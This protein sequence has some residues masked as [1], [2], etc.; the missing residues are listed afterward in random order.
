MKWKD[1]GHDDVDDDDDDNY[2]IY[3][4]DYVVDDDDFLRIVLGLV[5]P[6][7]VSIRKDIITHIFLSDYLLIVLLFFLCFVCQF[8]LTLDITY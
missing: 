8:H 7:F 1:F 2:S 5:V 3:D 6:A 4:N